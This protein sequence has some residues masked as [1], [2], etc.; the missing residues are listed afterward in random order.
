MSDI[1]LFWDDSQGAADFVVSGNDLETDDGLETAV[2]LSLFLDRRAE[3]SDELPAGQTDRRG[4][5]ADEFST[6]EG[7]R[8][9]SRLWLLARSKDV[10]SV[11][12][13][14]KQYAEEALQWLIDDLVAESLTATVTREVI[15][16]RDSALLMTID[17]ARP[18]KDKPTRFR[19]NYAWAAQQ[20]R[21]A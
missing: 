21:R 7:D 14:A 15:T 2:F 8:I 1:G 9:G 13:L 11:L 10:A 5:W 6:V 19:W 3:D 16:G 20:A 12:P 4:W 18:G 17:I